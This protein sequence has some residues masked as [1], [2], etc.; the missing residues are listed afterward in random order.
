MRETNILREGEPIELLDGLLVY[1]ERSSR[2]SDPMTVGP[3]HALAVRLLADQDPAVRALGWYVVTQSPIALPPH[4]EPE[5]DG[6]IVRG[7][8]RDYPDRVPPAADVACVIEVADSSLE[9]DR[10]R[11]LAIYA[12]AAIPQYVIVNLV[13]RQ[14][15]VHE[16]PIPAEGRYATRTVVRPGGLVPLRA[17]ERHVAVPADHL[18]P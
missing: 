7:A 1:K 15:E 17:G 9:T 16:Q 2:G 8:P 5:P 14:I 13:D 11:K 10:T 4:H 18:L 12:S 6:A 3:R